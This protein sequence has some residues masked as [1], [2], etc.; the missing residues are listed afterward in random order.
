MS[1]N[2]WKQLREI[3]DPVIEKLTGPGILLNSISKS[4]SKLNTMTIGWGSLGC[5]W[6]KPVFIVFVRPQ[7][8]TCELLEEHAEFTVNISKS[9]KYNDGI[10][11]AGTIS[12]RAEDKIKELG[13][14]PVKSEKISVPHFKEFEIS[15]ECK[16]IYKDALKEELVPAD[17]KKIF[18][19][20]K[21]FHRFYIG[22]ILAVHS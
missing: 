14:S 17:V 9:T 19:P 20:K 22:E 3:S 8:F 1:K 10:M 11:Y 16:I 15:I 12:G 21:D 2:I 18:Y 13:V 7:R 5:L 6:N 4:G